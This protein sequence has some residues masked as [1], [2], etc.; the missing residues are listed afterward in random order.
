MFWKLWRHSSSNGFAI[1]SVDVRPN[2]LTLHRP[3]RS[4]GRI[5]PV[6]SDDIKQ[7]CDVSFQL[8]SGG[9]RT[10]L[11]GSLTPSQAGSLR[12][13]R[14]NFDQLPIRKEH[15]PYTDAL[16]VPPGQQCRPRRGTHGQSHIEAGEPSTL[17]GHLIDTRRLVLRCPET[18][19]VGIAQVVVEDDDNVGL[20]SLA[21][22]SRRNQLGSGNND[23]G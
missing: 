22:L 11:L 6:R 10:R 21:W 3:R 9:R 7:A 17:F 1:V 19:N 5:A 13:V 14:L 18:A 4:N 2:G 23:R 8:A 15:A 16:R 12:H 20:I